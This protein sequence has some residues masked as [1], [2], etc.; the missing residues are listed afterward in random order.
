MRLAV[1]RAEVQRQAVDRIG[2]LCSEVDRLFAL[3]MD[4]R[5]RYADLLAAARATLGATREGE[6]DPLAY[7][8][9]ELPGVG[10]ER[11]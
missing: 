2:R 4:E 1:N 3:L 7:L 8:R 9:D 10:E 5:L 6:A 11:R